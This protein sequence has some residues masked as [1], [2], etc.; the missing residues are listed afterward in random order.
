MDTRDDPLPFLTADLP[1]IGGTIKERPEDF[2]VEEIPL[3]ELSGEGEHLFLWIEK[4]GVSAEQLMRHIARTLGISRG[5]V[6]MA[7]MK[8]R[9]AVTRQ[10]V[11]V[12][13]RCEARLAVLETDAVRVLQATR[14]R[15]KLRTG[16]LKGNR[17]TILI[18]AAAD[19]ALATAHR[20]A[21]RIALHGSPNYFGAQRFGSGGETLETGFELLRG[22]KDSRDLPA[23][24]RRFL[25][26]LSLSAVQSLLF[27]RTLAERLDGGLLHQVMAGDVMQ[28]VASGGPFVAED[29]QAEQQRF[30]AGETVITGPIFGPKMKCPTG[31]PACR[32]QRVLDAFQLRPDDFKRFAKLTPGTRRPYLVRPE[33]LSIASAPEG[34]RLGFVLPSGAYATMLLREFRKTDE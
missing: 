34:L 14:H 12:P 25:L 11:S 4:R 10:H 7:G 18:R 23:S 19:D 22:E 8:D 28:V 3:Y 1:G 33:G 29:V 6:G 9:Q 24:R 31:D 5:D 27:N 17:F 21:E 32:E 15:H 16:Q 26:R 30:D 2:E 20:I 13:A